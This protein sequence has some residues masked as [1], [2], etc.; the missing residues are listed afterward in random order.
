MWHGEGYGEILPEDIDEF[1]NMQKIKTDTAEEWMDIM[2][3]LPERE[4]KEEFCRLLREPAKKDWGG[5]SNDHF[6]NSVS[7]GGRRRTA[8]FLLKGPGSGFR[9]MTLDMCGKRADQIHRLA[10]SDADVSVV[11][12]AHLIGEVIRKT[13]RNY[14]VRPG[15]RGRKY[16]LIDGQSTYRI[17]KAYDFISG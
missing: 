7:I 4:V 3:T 17:L 13:L 11:Q 14:I 1:S 2:R 10:Q 12:H 16:C 6:S 8:A 5:E 15:G 9:E